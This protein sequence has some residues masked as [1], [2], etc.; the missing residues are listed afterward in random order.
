[1]HDVE[2]EGFTLRSDLQAAGSP[3]AANVTSVISG[4]AQAYL[5]SAADDSPVVA[6]CFGNGSRREGSQAAAG[7][8]RSP[9]LTQR[10]HAFTRLGG[11]AAK[12][13]VLTEAQAQALRT[14]F[15]SRPSSF[16]LFLPSTPLH[17]RTLRL[18]VT[19]SDRGPFRE[20]K[21]FT[22]NREGKPS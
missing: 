2:P 5:R 19:G 10:P 15:A 17:Q 22:A 1:M 16:F 13:T 9:Q 6:L 8:Q 4:A 18:S 14:F 11:R 3:A 20:N 7:T 21:L 12:R